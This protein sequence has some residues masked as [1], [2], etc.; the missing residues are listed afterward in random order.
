MGKDESD[1]YRTWHHSPAHLFLPNHTYIVTA[2]TLHKEHIFSGDRRLALLQNEL[3]RVSMEY[4]WQLQAWAM[5]SNHYHFVAQA[6]VQASSLQDMIRRFHSVTAL[7]VNKLD[8]S[9]GRKVWFQY[10]DTCLTY[11]KSYHARLKYVHYNAL[12]HGLASV[13]EDY[14]FCSAAWFRSHADPSLIRRV[15]RAGHDRI[16]IKDDF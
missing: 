2:G 13:A 5:F 11:E 8:G 3:F 16:R 12:K 14:P 10:W 1:V 4:G 7:R 15:E 6:P 9:I